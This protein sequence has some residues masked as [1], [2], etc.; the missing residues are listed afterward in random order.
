M[1]K[2]GQFDRSAFKNS[3]ERLFDGK[4][5]FD[6]ELTETFRYANTQKKGRLEDRISLQAEKVKQQGYRKE[7]ALPKGQEPEKTVK[8]T[9]LQEMPRTNYLN[10]LFKPTEENYEGMPRRKRRGRKKSLVKG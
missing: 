10:T 9:H 7:R 1:N 5:N 8:K 3:R 2:V 6:R 4:F